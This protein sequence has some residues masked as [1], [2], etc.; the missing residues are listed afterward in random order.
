MKRVIVVGS[1]AGGATAALMLQGKFQVTVL[2]AG[3]EFKPFS[4][5]LTVLEKLKKTGL[6]FDERSIQL[7]FWSMRV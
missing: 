1:G 4:F 7:L 5:S 2:E 3:R 6:F